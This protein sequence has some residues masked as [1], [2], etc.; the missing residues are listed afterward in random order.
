MIAT[1]SRKICFR[2]AAVLLG[3]LTPLVVGEVVLRVFSGRPLSLASPRAARVAM[4]QSAHPVQYDSQLGWVPRANLR[5]ERY[6]GKQATLTIRSDSTRSNG[7]AVAGDALPIVAVGDSFT[8]GEQVS[9]AETWP[10]LLER[11][12]NRPVINAGVPGYAFDQTVLRAEQLLRERPAAGLIVSLIPDDL[13]R[14]DNSY[15]Y[16]WKPYFALGPAGLELKNVPVPRDPLPS[17]TGAVWKVLGHSH[18]LDALL[19]RLAPAAY[20]SQ[21]DYCLEHAGSAAAPGFLVAPDM[22]RRLHDLGLARK[23]PVIVVV[24]PQRIHPL[25]S[26]EFEVSFLVKVAH[27]RGIQTLNLIPVL[28][29]LAKSQPDSALRWFYPEGHMTPE[30]NRWIAEQIAPLLGEGK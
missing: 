4:L 11:L 18:L 17:T 28:Q 30:G 16:A 6:L 25:A 29:S 14:C 23:V 27:N 1:A 10:A 2:L 24:Q 8:F 26:E 20:V 7:T 22:L 19:I 15:R 5:N 12:L 21:G 3:T 13:R 9:D